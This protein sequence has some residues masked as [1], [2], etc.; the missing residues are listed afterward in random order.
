VVYLISSDGFVA[1]ALY[2]SK[3]QQQ[4][5]HRFDNDTGVCVYEIQSSAGG[6]IVTSTTTGQVR[7]VVH[8][9]GTSDSANPEG[10]SNS[11]HRSRNMVAIGLWT[12]ILVC[13]TLMGVVRVI[14]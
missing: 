2:D 9:E 4:E 11:A 7:L 13:G 6:P 8:P 10:T 3:V 12:L 1:S 14:G 5:C